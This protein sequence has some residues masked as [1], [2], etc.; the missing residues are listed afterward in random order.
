MYIT[1]KKN[2]SGDEVSS[3]I[4]SDNNSDFDIGLSHTLVEIE[5]VHSQNTSPILMHRQLIAQQDQA[6][7]ESLETDM[8]KEES[9]RCQLLAE[10]KDAQRQENLMTS[11]SKKVPD[12]PVEGED[13]VNVHVRHTNS[14]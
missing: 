12:E 4:D 7:K 13:E 8:A 9:K 1:T 11:R 10:L 6:Y 5:E 3:G 14:S 2:G